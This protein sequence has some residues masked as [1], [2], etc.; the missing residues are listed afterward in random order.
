M[1]K[2]KKV[3]NGSYSRRRFRILIDVVN[4]FGHLIVATSYCKVQDPS[5][6]L[7]AVAHLLLEIV[8][9]LLQLLDS[10][11]LHLVLSYLFFELL[12]LLCVVG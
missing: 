1:A 2:V 10:L 3:W 4:F 6:L 12:Q 9:L 8:L 5:H 11:R 7:F